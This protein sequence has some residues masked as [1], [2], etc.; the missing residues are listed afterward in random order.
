ML[1][2]EFSGLVEIL[3]SLVRKY[4]L[5]RMYRVLGIYGAADITDRRAALRMDME[6][7][8]GIVL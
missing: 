2:S 6:L 1:C 8:K 4:V 3:V 5:I 7:P